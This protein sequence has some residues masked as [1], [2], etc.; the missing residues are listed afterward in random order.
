MKV[1]I[2]I[3]DISRIEKLLS[4]NENNLERIF[5][6][7]EIAYCKK[8]SDSSQHFAGLFCAKEAFS[9]ALGTGFSKGLK[10]ASIEIMHDNLGAPFVSEKT[11]HDVCPN[12]EVSISISHTNYMATAICVVSKAIK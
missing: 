6:K 12:C 11:I 2:D 1:G 10:F 9:K 3:E 4:E 8:F 5:S 7:N